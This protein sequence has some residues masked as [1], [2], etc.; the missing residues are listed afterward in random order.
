[1]TTATMTTDMELRRKLTTGVK[2]FVHDASSTYLTPEGLIDNIP[3]AVLTYYV[4]PLPPSSR[5]H[6]VAVDGAYNIVSAQNNRYLTASE[7]RLD[8]PRLR[9]PDP[10]LGD[11]QL[12]YF[13][14]MFGSDSDFAIIPKSVPGYALGPKDY[15]Y[16][17]SVWIAP[18]RMWAGMPALPQAW[19]I[20]DAPN[21]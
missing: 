13:R 15:N 21:E 2:I 14:P 1:M 8:W 10:G 4:D 19:M 5:W 12:W 18:T 11:R 9:A 7:T 16:G 20:A 6:I 3:N 17:P